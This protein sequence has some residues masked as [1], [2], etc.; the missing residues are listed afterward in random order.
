M[1]L[2]QRLREEENIDASVCPLCKTTRAVL[3]FL[4][5]RSKSCSPSY[6]FPLEM[7]IFKNGSQI[8]NT[9]T[10]IHWIEWISH[11]LIHIWCSSEIYGCYIWEVNIYY[12]MLH[13][14]HATV[15]LVDVFFI[16]FCG[17]LWHREIRF[18]RLWSNME[19]LLIVLVF[20]NLLK[21]N[22]EHRELE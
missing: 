18:I 20:W 5:V 21:N 15:W 6:M 11:G 1:D 22:R 4:R 19:Y 7:Q 13:V 8:C 14:T 17:A 12:I 10:V 2:I 16:R 9:F 3:S